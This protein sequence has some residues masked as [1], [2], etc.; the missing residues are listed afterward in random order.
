VTRRTCAAIGGLVAIACLLDGG[1]CA[2]RRPADTVS[3]WYM[4][5]RAGSDYFH[6]GRSPT[7]G[8]NYRLPTGQLDMGE[9]F[10]LTDDPA[11]W[12]RIK[13]IVQPPEAGS[14]APATQP[15]AR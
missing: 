11:Q 1:G 3:L 12:R 6:H 14:P 5:S 13:R 7:Q 9:T 4:G 2:S 10:P 8:A 15:E